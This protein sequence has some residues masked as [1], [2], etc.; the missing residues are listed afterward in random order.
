MN[1]IRISIVSLSQKSLKILKMLSAMKLLGYH[2]T[3]S[4]C[5]DTLQ[6]LVTLKSELYKPESPKATKKSSDNIYYV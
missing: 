2:L 5:S 3:L 6:P 4:I 1:F